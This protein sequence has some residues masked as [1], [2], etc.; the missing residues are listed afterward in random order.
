MRITYNRSGHYSEYLAV[1]WAVPLVCALRAHVTYSIFRRHFM[2]LY[3]TLPLIQHPIAL[4]MPSIPQT[5]A[6]ATED[7]SQGNSTLTA[8]VA[9]FVVI[10]VV[11]TVA[12]G[13]ILW[14]K[15]SKPLRE[16]HFMINRTLAKNGCDELHKS[17]MNN[18]HS[19]SLLDD[20]TLEITSTFYSGSQQ[21]LSGKGDAHEWHS[22]SLDNPPF[23]D[24]RLDPQLNVSYQKRE[25]TVNICHTL[26]TSRSC[27]ALV[28]KWS[29]PSKRSLKKGPM[30]RVPLSDK[31]VVT[32]PPGLG[33]F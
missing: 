31:R 9:I 8:K 11:L 23:A 20:T 15:L 26:E 17:N 22:K 33:W 21:A 27:Q 30:P 14:Y 16:R 2:Y 1:A 28:E 32:G 19:P 10:G 13:F 12:V 29:A 7:T 18:S 6:L 4:A 25:R 5:T 24:M 3:S